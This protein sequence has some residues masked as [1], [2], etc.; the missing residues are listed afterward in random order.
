MCLQ[1]LV[2]I[3]FI[4]V[5]SIAEQLNTLSSGSIQEFI[6][7]YLQHLNDGNKQSSSE[8]MVHES[9]PYRSFTQKSQFYLCASRSAS[10]SHTSSSQISKDRKTEAAREVGFSQW[11]WCYVKIV[12]GDAQL[13]NGLV[14]GAEWC[15]NAG[16]EVAY[17]NLTSGLNFFSHVLAFL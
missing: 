4:A 11:L 10:E 1:L 8:V 5:S 17:V 7:P 15:R 6:S 2:F 13:Q 14:G 12:N 16:L 9:T 3:V